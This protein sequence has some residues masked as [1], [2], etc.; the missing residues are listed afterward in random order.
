LPSLWVWSK[1]WDSAFFGN[2]L[3]PRLNTAIHA[4]K[5]P[6]RPFTFFPILRFYVRTWLVFPTTGVATLGFVSLFASLLRFAW[7]DHQRRG[8]LLALGGVIALLL[9]AAFM[10]AP[11]YVQYFYGATPFMFVGIAWCLSTLPLFRKNAGVWR[12]PVGL[13]L[14]CVCFGA[15]AYRHLGMM[16]FPRTWVPLAVHRQGI[17]IAKQLP[18]GLVLTIEP[19]YPLEARMEIDQRFAV[20]RFA[21]RVADMMSAAERRRYLMPGFDDFESVFYEDSPGSLLV[22]R[23]ADGPIEHEFEAIAIARGY[24]SARLTIPTGGLH[25]AFVHVWLCPTAPRTLP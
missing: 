17:E 10:P 23:G 6:G 1:A 13:W 18:P 8:E 5:E 15:S 21:P 16:P 3:Y 19:I 11:P 7:A 2:F 12:I 24:T 25:R 4:T 14:F 9:A 22:V 20:G